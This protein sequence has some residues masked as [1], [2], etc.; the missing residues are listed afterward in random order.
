MST[1]THTIYGVDIVCRF[2]YEPGEPPE[3]DH[4]GWPDAYYL[5]H[6]TIGGI[7]VLKILDPA[8]VQ[9]LEEWEGFR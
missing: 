4:P 3:I 5:T 1:A 9:M 7:D 6:A 8:V 2:D